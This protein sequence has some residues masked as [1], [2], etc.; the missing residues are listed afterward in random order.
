M[1]DERLAFSSCRVVKAVL[2]LGRDTSCQLAFLTLR[3]I[4]YVTGIE[5]RAHC[6]IPAT[7]HRRRQCNLQ[8]STQTKK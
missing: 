3:S 1:A 2:L 5:N 4:R 6:S 7:T 8:M